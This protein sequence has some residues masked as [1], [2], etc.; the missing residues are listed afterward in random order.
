MIKLNKILHFAVALMLFAT[1]AVNVSFAE[2]ASQNEETTVQLDF[3]KGMGIIG[4]YDADKNITVGDVANAVNILTDTQNMAERYFSSYDYE[5]E[6]AYSDVISTFVDIAGY[7]QYALYNYGDTSWNSIYM[8]ARDMNLISGSMGNAKDKITEKT[9]VNLSYRLLNSK[10]IEAKYTSDGNVSIYKT[11]EKYMSRVLNM[12][13]VTGVVSAVSFSSLRPEK[14]TNDDYIVIENS[15]YKAEKSTYE[16][17]IGKKV[18]AL[19]KTEDNENIII[20]LH[21]ESS[22]L[23]IKAEDIITGSA[24]RDG[25]SYYKNGNKH[26]AVR[27]DKAADALYNYSAFSGFKGSDLEIMH[28][29]LV[30]IDNDDD[31]A[32]EVIKIEEYETAMIFS[33]SLDSKAL[34]D[35]FGNNWSIDELIENNYPI[36]QDGKL[37][38]AG[39]IPTGK[40]A[41]FYKNK[42]G[43]IVRI[44]ITD[45]EIAG[46]VGEINPSEKRVKIDRDK[47][48]YSDLIA[49]KLEHLKSGDMITAYLDYYGAIAFFELADDAYSWGYMVNF[50]EEKGLNPPQVKIF[51]EKNEFVVYSARDT[52]KINGVSMK[53]DLA[54]APDNFSSGLWDEVGK[55][56]QL[57]KF[58]ANSKN[59]IFE[60]LTETN[61]DPGTT[62]RPWKMKDDVFTYY[63]NPNTICADT[64]LNDYTKVFLIPEDLSFEKRFKFGGYK[65]LSNDTDYTCKVYDIDE[66]RYAGVVLMRVSNYGRDN[67]DDLS[68]PVY[69]IES[70]SKA[71]NDEG[72]ETVWAM[73][74]KTDGTE[75]EIKFNRLDMEVEISSAS[76]ASYLELK[77]LKIGDIIQIGTDTNN[78]G[79]ASRVKLWYS[80]GNTTPYEIT[81]RI[82]YSENSLKTF[83]S[84]GWTFAYGVVKKQIKYGIMINNQT[85]SSSDDWD[86]VVTY[87][88]STPVW[89]VDRARNKIFR[90]STSDIMPG[91]KIFSLLRNGAPSSLYVYKN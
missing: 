25:I 69:L 9:L 17:F 86:R 90:A 5:K 66:D 39:N 75:V 59:E 72:D 31:G 57:V 49:E 22:V 63:S 30:L 60:I 53:S 77:D 61:Y 26:T 76:I 16:D 55:I 79:E 50:S 44:F 35:S 38:T 71:Q 41:T 70:V 11:D 8:T 88:P 83:I 40:V 73:A 51:T 10:S 32:Y 43:E 84:D 67:I 18:N 3:I 68:G 45:K 52:V 24:S 19:I 85:D 48:Y 82:W 1:S 29:S 33:V 21:D 42:S 14:E 27:F 47:Y 13:T 2:S 28:G 91:D 37:I 58:K 89:I 65:I 23:E 64:R 56:S 6:A 15:R 87:G 12:Y 54:F 74:R 4:D 7:T 20:A 34:T 81:K 36:Y 80:N 78:T 62:G 46:F